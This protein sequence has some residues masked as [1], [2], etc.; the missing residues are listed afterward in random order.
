M[1]ILGKNKLVQAYSK[2]Q[3]GNSNFRKILDWGMKARLAKT[4]L[5][6]FAAGKYFSND[7]NTISQPEFETF[8]KQSPI[9]YQ[10]PN[11]REQEGIPNIKQKSR[12]EGI[13]IIDIDFGG[14]GKGH[15]V[16]YLP[17]IPRSLDYNTE[18]TFVAI[19][20]MGR[21][22]PGYHFTGAEDKLEFE[23]DWCSLKEDK[24][25]VINACR[26]LEALSKGNSYGEAPHR[27]LLKWGEDDVL[28][29]NH[30]FVV[31]AAPYKMLNFNKG[32]IDGSGEIVYT[33][34]LP[35]LATQKVTL[36]RISS[37]NLT[38][39]DIEFLSN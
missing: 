17:F 39:G 34:M 22:N 30:V 4:A 35:A 10:D 23:I 14:Y 20:G 31:L 26:Q 18:S 5:T 33:A 15:R 24:T 12:S 38:S 7:P 37:Y 16:M 13:Q 27:I 8:L 32:Y 11:T 3:L 1:A 36:A 9:V 21:N 2:G 25:D 29:S 19:K 28:F 6:R